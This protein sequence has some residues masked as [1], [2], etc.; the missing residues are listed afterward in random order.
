M[1]AGITGHISFSGGRRTASLQLHTWSPANR[2][3]TQI[4]TWSSVHG[5]NITNNNTINI[6]HK[7]AT[8]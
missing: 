3:A 6:N 2:T 4:G 7:G 8:S 5:I 1:P